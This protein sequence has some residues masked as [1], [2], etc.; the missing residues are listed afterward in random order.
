MAEGVLNKTG[1]ISG[2]W[3]LCGGLNKARHIV[4]TALLV[5]VQCFRK[6][7][8]TR[9]IVLSMINASYCLDHRRRLGERNSFWYKLVSLQQNV[10]KFRRK[11][12]VW[13]KEFS[14]CYS[15]L[16][17][18]ITLCQQFWSN[19]MIFRMEIKNGCTT[20]SKS[21]QLRNVNIVQW[22][23]GNVTTQPWKINNRKSS[24]LS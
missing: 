23:S 13:S 5:R 2:P 4:P 7:P 11:F 14:K 21:N 1:L 19:L 20:P 24:R 9:P 8:S 15:K 17:I 10:T 6:G 12:E 18:S 22:D 16:V 3:R